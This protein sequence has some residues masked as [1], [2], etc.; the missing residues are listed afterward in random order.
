VIFL[1]VAL[2]VTAI[3]EMISQWLSIRATE[4]KTAVIGMLGGKLETSSV[5]MRVLAYISTLLGDNKIKDD[6][7]FLDQP[8]IRSVSKNETNLPSYMD[9]AHFSAAL[10]TAIDPD[11]AARNANE[12]AAAI[13]KLPVP[14]DT[15]Q[16][17]QSFLKQANGNLDQFRKQIESW[18]DSVMDRVSGWYKRRMAN[19]VL[20]FAAVIVV[21]GNIDTLA[22][23]Q[24]LYGDPALREKMV[25][26]ASGY[27]NQASAAQPV[28]PGQSAKSGQSTQPDKPAQSA[29]P[30]QPA[31]PSQ[32]PNPTVDLEK[33]K[34][35]LEKVRA[36]GLPIGWEGINRASLENKDSGW[37]LSKIFGW[38]ITI[39]AASLGAP[40]WFDMLSKIMNIRN[41]G[42][43]TKDT[44]QT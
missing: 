11:Y 3:S 16:L 25:S 12:I 32:S 9:A 15:R 7:W 41:S 29:Q 23:S 20:V 19:F 10:L 28:Q 6:H 22:I 21:G 27:A 44:A 40:F 33:Y 34:G 36:A 8:L 24:A 4:F 30:G 26:L 2:S 14:D 5:F 37:W 39:C 1:V 17:L 31:Q 13:D 38:L 42:P 18:F 43:K 35:D